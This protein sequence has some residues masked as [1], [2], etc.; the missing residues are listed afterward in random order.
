MRILA[1]IHP[2]EATQAIL[3]CLDMPSRSPPLRPPAPDPLTD[4]AQGF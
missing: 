1:A 3:E 4:L 2:P